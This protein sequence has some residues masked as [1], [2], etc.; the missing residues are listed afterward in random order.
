MT[1]AIILWYFLKLDSDAKLAQIFQVTTTRLVIVGLLFTATVWCGRLY[2]ATK[3]QQ[4]VNKHRA[5]ALKTFR[6]FVEAASDSNMRDA[7]LMETTR[8]I[9]AITPSGYINES[10]KASDSGTRV[11]EIVKSVASTVGKGDE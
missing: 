2:K 7:V 4:S 6:A 3:H 9:F 11:V 10:V 5:N 1:S 8:S